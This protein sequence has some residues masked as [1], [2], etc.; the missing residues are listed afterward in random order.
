MIIQIINEAYSEGYDIVVAGV[1][2]IGAMAVNNIKEPH[3]HIAH[4]LKMFSERYGDQPEDYE[5]VCKQC[6]YIMVIVDFDDEEAVRRAYQYT[7]ISKP[8]KPADASLLHLYPRN[9]KSHSICITLSKYN[10][11]RYAKY[12][13]YFDYIIFV[14]HID[15]LHLPVEFLLLKPRGSFIGID[16]C[17]IFSIFKNGKRAYMIEINKQSIPKAR[18]LFS[19]QLMK[20]VQQNGIKKLEIFFGF[21]ISADSNLDVIEDLAND[22][23]AMA[24]KVDPSAEILWSATFDETLSCLNNEIWIS[25]IIAVVDG[26]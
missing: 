11:D 21:G 6:D 13:D 14:D 16:I 25:A 5:D 1:G 12:K 18:A 10:T 4:S 15:Q 19:D 2:E 7:K 22:M 8:R 23:I 24:H 20:T 26:T 3:R 9:D 17:D